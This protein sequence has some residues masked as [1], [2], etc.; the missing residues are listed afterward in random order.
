MSVKPHVFGALEQSRKIM[1]KCVCKMFK[2][3]FF[4]LIRKNFAVHCR[5]GSLEKRERGGGQG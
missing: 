5:I 3:L 2:S 4:E 1:V